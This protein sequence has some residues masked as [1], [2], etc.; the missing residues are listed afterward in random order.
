VVTAVLQFFCPVKVFVS[1]AD[2]EAA[3]TMSDPTAMQT[4]TK[5]AVIERFRGTWPGILTSLNASAHVGATLH[6]W[7]GIWQTFQARRPNFL[8]AGL[9]C[10]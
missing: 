9:S 1:E 5:T 2:A 8:I 3:R 7:T 6:I 4:A 10:Q